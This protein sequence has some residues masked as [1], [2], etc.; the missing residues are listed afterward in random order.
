MVSRSTRSPVLGYSDRS[1]VKLD[2]DKVPLRIVKFWSRRACDW[3][4]LEGFIILESSRGSFHVVYDR[5]VTWRRNMHIIAWVAVESQLS[6]LRDYVLMQVIKESSTLRVGPKFKKPSPR[7]V[8]RYGKQDRQI[9][10][11]LD[12]R[13]TI[14]HVSK[15][16]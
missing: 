11:F 16:L 8:Y 3:F 5:P 1:T 6:K 15:N 9:Q 14:N 2:Y 7:I 12:M 13:K 10:E 4:K